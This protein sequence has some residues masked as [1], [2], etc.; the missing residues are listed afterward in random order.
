MK[1]LDLRHRGEIIPFHRGSGLGQWL[2]V[3]VSSFL[4]RGGGGDA[5]LGL[6]LDS[7]SGGLLEKPQPL[8]S[9]LS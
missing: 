7:S 5:H 8:Y 2:F 1:G 9:L 6:K 3:R 4:K